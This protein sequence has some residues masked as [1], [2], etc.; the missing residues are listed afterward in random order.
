MFKFFKKNK[1]A[2]NTVSDDNKPATTPVLSQSDEDGPGVK[3]KVMGV[4]MNMMQR[5]AMKKL[6]KMSPSEQAKMMQ[7]M[8]KPENKG[9]LLDVMEMMKKSGQI[10]E[11]QYNEAKKRLGIL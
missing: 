8:M 4:G 3:D 11:E 1:P 7:D 9:K 2:G 5:V 10:S 6:A